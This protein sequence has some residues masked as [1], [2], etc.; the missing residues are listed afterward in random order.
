MPKRNL[1]RTTSGHLVPR[2]IYAVVDKEG[3]IVDQSLQ[4]REAV[5]L[6]EHHLNAGSSAVVIPY[7]PKNGPTIDDVRK[8]IIEGVYPSLDA[9]IMLLDVFD[10][11][12]GVKNV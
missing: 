4:E 3:T 1:Q 11:Q 7:V 8:W 12:F 10:R 2:A 6:K 9:N 5:D